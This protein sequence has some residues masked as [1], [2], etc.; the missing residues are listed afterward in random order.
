MARGGLLIAGQPWERQY[1]ALYRDHAARLTQ[2][3]RL[4]L[5]DAA[6]AQDVVQEVLAKAALA[7][8]VGEP[9]R[10]WHP[11]LTRVAVR[12]C[13]SRARKGWWRRFHRQSVPLEATVLVDPQV[14]PDDA[15]AGREAHAR[16]WE[17]YR[18]LSRRQREV[19]VLRHLEQWSTAEVA[20]ELGLS[21]GAVK[22]H[23]FRAVHRLRAALGGSR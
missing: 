11:W 14:G 19:L 20:A 1:E 5:R 8:Q 22:A 21:E 3:A 16:V 13:Q 12:A 4:F 7:L 17:A 10:Q 2:L 18:A 23:L 6:E 9:P 15:A